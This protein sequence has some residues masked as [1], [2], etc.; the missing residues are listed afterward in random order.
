MRTR[1]WIGAVVC[2]VVAAAPARAQSQASTLL[3]GV[4][5]SAIVQKPIDMANV[6]APA[7]IPTQ[8]RFS[9]TSLVRR[10]SFTSG[11]P[12]QAI[13]PFPSPSSF[14]SFPSAKMAGKP[15]ILIGDPNLSANPFQ[16]VAPTTMTVR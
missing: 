16:P 15:P 10:L 3:G 12:T 9:F 14:P 2:L 4:S 5:P 6:V 13:S 1:T 11:R 7:T 8:S